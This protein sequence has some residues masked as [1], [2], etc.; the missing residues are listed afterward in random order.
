MFARHTE[1]WRNRIPSQC[2]GF[3]SLE[4]GLFNAPIAGDDAACAPAA[5]GSDPSRQSHERWLICR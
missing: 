1:L 2:G 5:F 3:L 4:T